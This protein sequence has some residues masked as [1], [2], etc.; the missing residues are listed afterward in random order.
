M[1]INSIPDH[2]KE[3]MQQEHGTSYLITDPASNNLL[4]QAT[5]NHMKN[6]KEV[7]DSWTI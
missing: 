6:K 4:T 2:N 1:A 5:K 3:I 7:R